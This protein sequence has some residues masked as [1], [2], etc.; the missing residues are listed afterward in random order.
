MLHMG[1]KNPVAQTSLVQSMQG[2]EPRVG[3]KVL[4]GLHE[5][6]SLPSGPVYPWLQLQKVILLLF[7]GEKVLRGQLTQVVAALWFFAYLPASHTGD[8]QKKYGRLALHVSKAVNEAIAAKMNFDTK[9]KSISAICT[10]RMQ[11]AM[12]AQTRRNS[13]TDGSLQRQQGKPNPNP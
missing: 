8:T 7:S 5:I 11:D 13:S 2:A 4:V 9:T 6:Q 12:A 10:A 1:L 3:L